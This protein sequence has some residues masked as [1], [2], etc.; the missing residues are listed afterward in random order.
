MKTSTKDF[1][2]MLENKTSITIDWS[3]LKP[4]ERFVQMNG[5]AVE[6]D[7]LN[8]NGGN[9][10]M[11]VYSCGCKTCKEVMALQIFYG[12]IGSEE[13]DAESVKNQIKK[14]APKINVVTA[15]LFDLK[16]IA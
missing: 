14:V 10:I 6:L 1:L 15:N 5:Q 11:L 12:L 16:S 3:N 13:I 2:K 8:L 9:F 4:T 7:T